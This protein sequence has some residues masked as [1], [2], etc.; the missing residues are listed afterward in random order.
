MEERWRREEEEEKYKRQQVDSQKQ[1]QENRKKQDEY[2]R[3]AESAAS[4]ITTIYISNIPYDPSE[5]YLRDLCE[6]FGPVVAIKKHNQP[7]GFVQFQNR[8]DAEHAINELHH[9][10]RGGERITVRWAT[11]QVKSFTERE[12]KQLPPSPERGVSPQLQNNTKAATIH[13]RNVVQQKPTT[14]GADHDDDD[15]KRAFKKFDRSQREPIQPPQPIQ[16][17]PI[18]PLFQQPIQQ[19]I[20]R[21]VCFMSRFL[22]LFRMDYLENK[23]FGKFL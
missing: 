8:E 3:R 7:Y 23:T 10:D 4:D 11:R 12:G 19:S 5:N 18:Q 9:Y 17:Q 15:D 22:T 13:G 21:Q 16:Q 6:K 20:T 1:L 14:I 2:I